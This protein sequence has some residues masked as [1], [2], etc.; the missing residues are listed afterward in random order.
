MALL[1][2]SST[3]KGGK[4]GLLIHNP[5]THEGKTTIGIPYSTEHP[6]IIIVGSGIPL[7]HSEGSGIL[8]PEYYSKSAV[9]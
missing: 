2:I 6:T 1:R 8:T 4:G 7:H 9:E 3:F 5:E